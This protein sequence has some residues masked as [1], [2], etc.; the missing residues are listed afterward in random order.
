M[1]RSLRHGSFHCDRG[2]GGRRTQLPNS[3]EASRVCLRS[4]ELAS[5]RI[6]LVIK[7]L[8]FWLSHRSNS[9]MAQKERFFVHSHYRYIPAVF[10]WTVFGPHPEIGQLFLLGISFL[11]KKEKKNIRKGNFLLWVFPK[12]D[13][14][15]NSPTLMFHFLSLIL[16][17]PQSSVRHMTKAPCQLRT[18]PTAIFPRDSS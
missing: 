16:P 1:W 13:R 3:W 5:G 17:T 14:S 15:Y 18:H 4:W 12:E 9:L 10:C 11:L 6:V 2:S 8:L 7:R